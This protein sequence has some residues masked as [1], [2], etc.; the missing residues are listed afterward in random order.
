MSE[1]IEDK[2]GDFFGS[3]PW[4]LA[5]VGAGFFG[6]GAY[7]TYESYVAAPPG[8]TYEIHWFFMLAGGFMF[9]AGLIFWIVSLNKK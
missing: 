9:F 6:W 7:D 2:I 3:N 1:T 5:L 8:G 4:A